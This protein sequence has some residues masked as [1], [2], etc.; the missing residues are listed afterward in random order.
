MMIATLSFGLLK[1]KPTKKDPYISAARSYLVEKG[2]RVSPPICRRLRWQ[3]FL[4]L[5][6]S[7]N[8]R[9][10]FALSCFFDIDRH[11]LVVA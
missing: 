10:S 1:S 6:I 7:V 3:D 4:R 2:F 8:C 11:R 5:A 9:R